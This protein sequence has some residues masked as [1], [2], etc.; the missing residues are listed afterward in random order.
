[1]R[2]GHAAPIHPFW[3]SSVRRTLACSLRLVLWNW[4][5][6]GP[7]RIKRLI[8]VTA[9]SVAFLLA[10]PLFLAVAA[11]VKIEDGGPVLHWQKRVGRYG[12]VFAF[13]KFRSMYVDAERRLAEIAHQNQHGSGITFKMKNDPRVTRVG[14]VI[15][16]FSVDEMPQLWCVLKGDMTLVG[17][18]PALPVEVDRYTVEDRRR[19]EAIPGLTCTWQVGGRSDIPFPQQCRMDID[20]IEGRSLLQDLRLIL[21]TV[22][23]ILTGRGAY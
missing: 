22:P 9:S 2:L 1:M 23:A 16:R 6:R 4:S 3:A 11:M 10:A 7:D 8:D 18:R 21:A 15:R 17:P 12:R 13:P 14:R 5:T 19:L 20:Y